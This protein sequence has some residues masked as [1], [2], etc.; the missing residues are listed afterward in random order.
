SSD[1]LLVCLQ[2]RPDLKKLKCTFTSRFHARARPI[3]NQGIT[4]A[5]F[6]EIYQ[7]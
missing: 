1:P 6:F 2:A 7:Y 4:P 5:L 3:S